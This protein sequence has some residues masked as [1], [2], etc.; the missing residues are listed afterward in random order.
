VRKESRQLYDPLGISKN[1][2]ILNFL[3]TF[4]SLCQ[5]LGGLCSD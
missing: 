2:Q 4:T 1:V 3:E 5:H